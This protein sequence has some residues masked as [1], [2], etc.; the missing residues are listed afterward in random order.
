MGSGDCWVKASERLIVCVCLLFFF[1]ISMPGLTLSIQ[2]PC[3][4][5]TLGK[6]DVHTSG[7]QSLLSALGTIR[8]F[9]LS[10]TTI[11]RLNVYMRKCHKQSSILAELIWPLCLAE[12]KK[13]EKAE[14]GREWQ[15]VQRPSLRKGGIGPEEGTRN[16]ISHWYWRPARAM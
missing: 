6:S 1:L 7:W 15:T 14:A 2:I 9:W 16:E 4:W 13:V 11:P 5:M 8:I 10:P 3:M 12:T